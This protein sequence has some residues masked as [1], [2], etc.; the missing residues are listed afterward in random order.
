MKKQFV[1]VITLL[2]TGL[3]V[4]YSCKKEKSCEG[5]KEN[6]KPPIAIAGPDQV[7]TLPTDSI[8]LDGS[9]SSDPDGKISEWRWKKIEGPASFAIAD[10]SV[11]KTKAR[12]L[13]VG[14]YQ[15][16]LTVTDDK[17]AFAKDTLVVIVD[18]TPT[19]H[20]PIGNAGAD[21]TI[22]L[23]TNSVTLDG[24][25]STDPDNNITSYQWTKIE[26]PS[27]FAIASP[28]ATQ[29]KVTGLEAGVYKFELKVTD[30]GGLMA[31]DTMQITVNV[32]VPVNHLP[33][34]NAGRDTII[35]LPATTV[36]LDGS[37][38]TDPDNNITGYAWTKISGPPSF[39]ITN[40]SAV[41][42]QAINLVEGVYHFELRVS[43]AG[44]LM[45]KDT[46][47][48]T[49]N[50]SPPTEADRD[51]Y[52]AG[53]ETNGSNIGVAKYW[54]NGVAVPLTDGTKD[55]G[56]SSITVV[57]SDVYVAG[58]ETNRSNI[59]VAKYWKNGVAIL[60]TD[61]TK[62]ANAWSIA[63]VGS[64]VYVAGYEANGGGV[65]YWKN[66]IAVILSNEA[67]VTSDIAIVGSDVY[68]SGFVGKFAKYWK[69]G[70]EFV[71][72]DGA[73]WA[74]ANSIAV[75]GSDVYVAGNE[76]D[77]GIYVVKYWKNGTAVSLKQGDNA[78]A[79]SI[80]VVGGNV[81]VAGYDDFRSTDMGKYWKNGQEFALSDPNNSAFA[82]DIA[83]AGSD[84]YVAGSESG[85]DWDGNHWKASVA[86]YWKNGQ[87]ISLTDGTKNAWAAGIAVMQH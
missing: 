79:T 9:A 82:M 65:K 43:D 22:I 5:C 28:N 6:N 58:S 17:G 29:T 7:I 60:L 68:V 13:V 38:S 2:L 32:S 62:N 16:E 85:W 25:G 37:K 30:A 42:T 84:V 55:A 48:V 64:D 23:P 51:I 66:G 81:Y 27:S 36:N 71:L 8:S 34:A 40:A 72:N 87:A 44:G 11:A 75:A 86:K 61:G 46:M 50:A 4:F 49:V 12:I 56:A 73:K 77:G 1:L 67:G 15:F 80:A 26:G 47:Q 83:V 59:Q 53:Y 52:V 57:G 35:T 74:V 63:V 24:S 69:N 54:K 20:P 33:I 76:T 21:Q 31:K 39:D 19:N 78:D 18:A 14:T 45:A 70:Q 10:S 41:Q 3:T